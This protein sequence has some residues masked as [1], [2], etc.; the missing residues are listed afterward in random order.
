MKKKYLAIGLVGLL[1][2][3]AGILCAIYL[4]PRISFVFGAIAGAGFGGGIVILMKYLYY[5]YPKNKIQYEKRLENE[6]IE[7]GDER[8]KH[9]R[10]KAGKYTYF[11]GLIITVFAIVVFIVLGN[12]EIILNYKIFVFYL[13]GYLVSQYIIGI[14]IFSYLNKKY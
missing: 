3:V 12:L 11:L 7:Q 1:I 8:K 5:I 2:G 10:D 13:C 4:D 9:L 14:I 6:G